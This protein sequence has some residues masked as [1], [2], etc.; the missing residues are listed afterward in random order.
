MR[1]KIW[2]WALILAVM[3][4]VSNGAWAQSDFYVI[5]AG[6]KAVGTKIST[7][8]YTITTPGFYYL[9]GNL[10][11]SSSTGN[12]ITINADDVTL[13]LMGNTLTGPGVATGT[14]EAITMSG[15]TNVEVRNGTVRNFFVGVHDGDI[16]NG[17]EHRAI[18]LRV[19]NT[20]FGIIFDGKNHLIK[21]CSA[22]DNANTGLHIGSGLI[23]DCVANYNYIGIML[24]GP[25]SV[26]GNT[27][28]NNTGYN[29]ALGATVITSTSILVDR[30]SAIGL[31][32]NYYK[33]VAL[34][35]LITNNNSG[36]P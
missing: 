19:A 31:P 36:T 27:A 18:N 15:R 17:K 22:T 20:T 1:G 24:D 8:P 11:Y 30:N 6:P 16:N 9:A 5:A 3:M 23:T 4:A 32:T 25:G 33:G 35:V 10:N 7:V 34:G 13:D 28:C 21:N 29:F 12:A 14:V 2:L 26:L